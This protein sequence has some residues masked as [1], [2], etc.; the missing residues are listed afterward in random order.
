MN[1]S[2]ITNC[3]GAAETV[4]VPAVH[5]QVYRAQEG[6][7]YSHHA[8]VTSHVGRLYATWSLGTVNEDDLGQRMVMATSDDLGRSWSPPAVVVAP[9]PS[10][11]VVTNGGIRPLPDGSGLAAFFGQYEYN[12]WHIK[13][14]QRL[15]ADGSHKNVFT[16]A[17]VS[18]DGGATWSAPKVVMR[19]IVP[20]LGPLPIGGHRLILPGCMAYG[21]TDDTAGLANWTLA[22]LPRLGEEHVDDS[23]GWQKGKRARGDELGFCE[24]SFF[25]TDDG[26]IHMMLR[27]GTNRLAV[28]ESRN[29]G[30][31]WSE[32]VLTEYSDN[33]SRLHFGRLA[34]GRYFGLTTPDPV[35]LWQRTPLVLALS[36]DG[37]RFD[38]HFVLGDEPN[39]PPRIPGMHKGGRYGYPYFHVMGEWCFAIYSVA[40]EDIGI[41]RFPL[42]ELE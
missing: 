27:T 34:D 33:V 14:G 21:Y 36:G 31:T 20:N 39:S 19:N 29:D 41:C 6:G 35:R 42:S 15:P 32:P 5:Y 28:T 13:D 1:T 3:W 26:I 25:Q 10:A 16:G 9:S 23:E 24:G 22:R 2:P 4:V 40:K 30:E 38:R 18:R 17:A 37:V 8:Q 7:A 11:A 12:N